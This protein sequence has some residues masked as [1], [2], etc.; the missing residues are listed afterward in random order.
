MSRML[1]GSVVLPP[2]TMN[3]MHIV[4][5][6]WYTGREQAMSAITGQEGNMGPA[7]M[8][9]RSCYDHDTELSL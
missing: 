8:Q 9:S 3:D 4:Y 7:L 2:H 6:T 5:Y 1:V